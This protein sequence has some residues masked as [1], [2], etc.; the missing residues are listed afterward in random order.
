M[1]IINDAAFIIV[2]RA[3]NHTANE[4]SKV[5]ILSFTEGAWGARYSISIR[6][7]FGT[8]H[9]DGP[10]VPLHKMLI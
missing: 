7:A 10:E 1:I 8:S 2:V 4:I 6:F 3:N 9:Q 5:L